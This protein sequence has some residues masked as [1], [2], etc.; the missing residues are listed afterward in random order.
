MGGRLPILVRT[1]HGYGLPY[2][3]SRVKVTMRLGR[4][5]MPTTFWPWFATTNGS[6]GVPSSFTKLPVQSGL[7]T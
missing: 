2:C 4:L 6:P 7:T 3:L 1:S 5:L